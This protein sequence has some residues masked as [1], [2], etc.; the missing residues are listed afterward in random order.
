MK[1]TITAIVAAFAVASASAQELSISTT[2]GYESTY[3]FRGAELA[4]DIFH[5]SVDFAYGDFYAGIWTAQPI[6]ESQANEI[7]FYAGYGVAVSDLVSLDF[8][9]T[10]YYYPEAGSGDES[11]F[12]AYI[13]AAFDVLASPAIYVYYDF[14]LEWVTVEGSVGYSIPLSEEASFDLGGYIGYIDGDDIDGG[15]YVGAT[16]D[17]SYTFTDYASGSIGIRV[18]DLDDDLGGDGEFYW[19][20]SFSAGF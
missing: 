13:G 18:S 6:T 8:G 19:G 15:Y 20:A 5:G 4:D 16:A 17:I 7:D 1:K 2:V 3:I 11:T 12:E 14:D 9:G 10:I